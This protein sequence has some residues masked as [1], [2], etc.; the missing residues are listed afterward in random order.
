MSNA[1]NPGDDCVVPWRRRSPHAVAVHFVAACKASVPLA[2]VWSDEYTWMVCGG[3]MRSSCQSDFS[4]LWLPRFS[5][6][7]DRHHTIAT[8]SSCNA[9]YLN[10]FRALGR[11]QTA[12]AARLRRPRRRW[13]RRRSA[14]WQR[15]MSQGQKFQFRLQ[16][17]VHDVG[18]SFP[19]PAVSAC[20]LGLA[21]PAGRPSSHPRLQRRC[22]LVV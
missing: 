15:P 11:W 13:R 8:S 22:Q 2:P 16:N 1:T 4:W 18:T 3:L 7:A 5:S 20:C 21:V 19:S 6:A 12:A 9:P 10:I 14:V 17:C